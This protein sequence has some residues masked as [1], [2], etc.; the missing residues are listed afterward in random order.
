MFRGTV[1]IG[2]PIED[3]E[4]IGDKRR[5]TQKT[6]GVHFINTIIR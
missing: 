4:K 1:I 5:W 6:G 3:E 2:L